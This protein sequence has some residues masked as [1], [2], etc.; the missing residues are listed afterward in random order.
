MIGVWASVTQ[1][2][3]IP[4]LIVRREDTQV[5]PSYKLLVIHAQQGVVGAQ[6]LRV[7]DHLH[8]VFA[9]VEELDLADLAQDRVLVVVRHI[10]SDNWR[11]GV[12]LQGENAALEE[13][14]VLFGHDMSGVWNAAP[15]EKGV[16]SDVQLR[17]CCDDG[18]I[19]SSSFENSRPNVVLDLGNGILQLLHNSL[20]LKGVNSET[21]GLSGHDDE[22]NNCNGRVVVL[23]AC[24]EA[25]H[26]L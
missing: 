22:G 2:R 1:I 7:E 12:A 25:C 5:T 3:N 18:Q 15:G 24:V 23:E 20:T 13:D 21:V 14:I 16:S 4:R 8:A 11:E 6:E 26:I 17:F 9:R 19:P 10:V